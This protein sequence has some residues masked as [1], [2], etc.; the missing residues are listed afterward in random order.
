M[1]DFINLERSLGLEFNNKELL[2]QAFC[3]RS[4][5]N[6]QKE[7]DCGHNERLEFLGDAVLELVVTEYLY[8]KYPAKDEGELTNWRASL[9][10]SKMLAQVSTDLGFNEYLL[11]SKGESKEEG[12]ARQYILAN[13][14]EAFTGAL[15]LDKGL[16]SCY[17]V[18]AQHLLPRLDEIIRT[19]SYRDPKSIFQEEAQKK[20]GITPKYQVLSESGP[21]HEKTFIVGVYL[22]QKLI[23][24]GKGSSKHEAEEEAARLALEIQE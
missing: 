2:K 5:I 15:Y 24:K 13:T 17:D 22:N 16:K 9:V 20:S 8:K 14:F 7:E 19:G 3:H 4:Y 11:L 23:A 18:I 1:K 6:E 10:N 21:D 12:K